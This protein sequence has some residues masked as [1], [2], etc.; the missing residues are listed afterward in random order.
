MSNAQDHRHPPETAS[1]AGFTY[2]ELLVASAL[3][4]VSLLTL[5][6]MFIAG[7]SNVADAGNT[8]RGLA[9]VRQVLED[10]RRLPYDN[11]TDLDGFDTDNPATLPAADPAREIARRWRYALAGEGLGWAFTEEEKVR[12]PTL[13]ALG[14]T[15]DGTGAI[16]VVQ[17]SATLTAITVTVTV[18][19]RWFPIEIST[20]IARL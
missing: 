16:E 2:V 12:W 18:P 4:L 9:A 7:Y 13:A 3:L 6:G 17:Q 19:G 20:V 14:E 15:L 5:A 8:T 1:I 10:A 11:L